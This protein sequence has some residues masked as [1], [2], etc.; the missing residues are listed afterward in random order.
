MSDTT[1][2]GESGEGW[3]VLRLSSPTGLNKLGMETLELLYQEV[4]VALSGD[5]RCLALVGEGGS[6]AVGADL[7]EVS[8]LTPRKAREFSDLGNRIFRLLESSASIVVAGIDGFCLGGGLDLALC[9]DW[10][11]ATT[12]SVFAHPGADLGII[13][14]FG[15]TQRLPRLIGRSRAS[16]WLFSGKRIRAAEAYGSGLLQEICPQGQ[17]TDH[18]MARIRHFSAMPASWLRGVKYGFR[19][20]SEGWLPAWRTDGV[21]R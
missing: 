1:V 8:R 6:F 15:G 10:C 17:F 19:Y 7:R 3:F 13:T 5:C 16:M 20:C 9:A 11:L 12:R 18:L 21:P 4:L 14:G 2:T